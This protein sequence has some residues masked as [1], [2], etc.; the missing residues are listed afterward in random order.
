MDY[1]LD[2]NF[3]IGFLREKET[4]IKKYLEIKNEKLYISTISV[5]ETYAGCR[6]LE[7]YK[8]D[9]LIDSLLVLKVNAR[10]ARQ[11]GRAIY[12]YSKKGKTIHKEDAIIGTTAKVFNLKLITQNTKDFPMLYPS[13]IEGFPEN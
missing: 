3:L 1:L 13:Q 10:I 2:T 6:E 8:T 5:L 4:H 11:A 12:N 9:L 7:I